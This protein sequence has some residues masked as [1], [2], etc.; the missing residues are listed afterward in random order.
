MPA[1]AAPDLDVRGLVEGVARHGHD[2]HVPSVLLQPLGRHLAA[3]GD[4][5]YG[6]EFEGLFAVLSQLAE[7]A[8]VHEGF[9][10]GEV[11]FFHA[12][13]LEEGHCALG[14]GEWGD[15]GGGSGVEA[16]AAAVVALA[17][18][19]V[20]DGEGNFFGWGG[21]VVERVVVM[22]SEEGEK[23]KGEEGEEHFCF[24]F[25]SFFPSFFF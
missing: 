13:T 8:G 9:A 11:Y 21:V 3:V 25:L 14:C 20:V 23:E 22:E 1:L 18:E 7:E 12:R 15:V 16:E 24:C 10:A 4:N 2:V 17:R 19:V 6:F 5:G